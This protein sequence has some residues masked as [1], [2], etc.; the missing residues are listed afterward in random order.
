MYDSDLGCEEDGLSGLFD[1]FKRAASVATGGV[2]FPS[3]GAAGSGSCS[4]EAGYQSSNQYRI[5]GARWSSKKGYWEFCGVRAS[6]QS[7]PPSGVGNQSLTGGPAYATT[8]G[9]RPGTTVP[10]PSQAYPPSSTV[11][12]PVVG[13]LATT[14]LLIAGAAVLGIVFLTRQKRGRR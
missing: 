4:P 10:A 7:P 3:G 14:P 5:D 8:G 2:L 6:N 11:T 12:L 9:I 13:Q 1:I